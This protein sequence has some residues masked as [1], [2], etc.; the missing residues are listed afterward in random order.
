MEFLVDDLL[1]IIFEFSNYS[2]LVHLRQINKRFYHLIASEYQYK[3]FKIS[4]H[5]GDTYLRVGVNGFIMG[6]NV[7]D[8]G[9]IDVSADTE[10]IEQFDTRAFDI[11][12]DD[13]FYL[14]RGKFGY[15]TNECNF[16]VK[17]KGR[18]LMILKFLYRIRDNHRQG[19]LDDSKR[20]YDQLDEK[21]QTYSEV[22]TKKLKIV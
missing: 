17:I 1:L 14:D 20:D 19:Q 9:S 15:T 3:K 12:S 5:G 11:P 13:L 7:P 2:T 6:F 18:Q 10:F 16:C 21:Y 22:K 8:L 4:T